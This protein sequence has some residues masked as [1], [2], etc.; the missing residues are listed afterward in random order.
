MAAGLAVL[1]HSRHQFLE[2]IAGG[3]A[4]QPFS[5]QRTRSEVKSMRCS[6]MNIFR[7]VPIP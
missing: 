1:R 7:D 6:S 2:S 5:C 3:S 4:K